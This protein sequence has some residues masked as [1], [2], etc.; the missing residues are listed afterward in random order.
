MHRVGVFSD[1]LVDSEI[2]AI[3]GHLGSSVGH[4]GVPASSMLFSS[5]LRP[6]RM[7]ED[8]QNAQM[9]PGPKKWLS[10]GKKSKKCQID[11]R[12]LKVLILCITVS[13]SIT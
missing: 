10:P 8:G 5:T 11:F 4:E 9:P 3:L 6:L 7:H 13:L 1:F 12:A 2:S